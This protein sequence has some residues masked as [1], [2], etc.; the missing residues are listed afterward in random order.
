MK[1][2]YE[3]IATEAQKMAQHTSS[4]LKTIKRQNTVI[5][6]RNAS[7]AS[8]RKH[9]DT[10]RLKQRGEWVDYNKKKSSLHQLMERFKDL[11]GRVYIEGEEGDRKY[12]LKLSLDDIRRLKNM[13]RK[14]G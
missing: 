13:L 8:A 6:K 3:K 12:F 10:K 7:L 2:K 5:M 11:Y 1:T 9:Y 4:V 14:N